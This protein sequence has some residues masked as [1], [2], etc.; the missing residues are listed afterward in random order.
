MYTST[1]QQHQNT[2]QDSAV[3]HQLPPEKFSPRPSKNGEQIV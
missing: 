2:P 3:K 1:M